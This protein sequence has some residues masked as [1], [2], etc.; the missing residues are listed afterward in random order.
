MPIAA[1]NDSSSLEDCAV[2]SKIPILPPL[3]N[4]K[5]A[6]EIKSTKNETK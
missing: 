4:R 3:T 6:N 2:R 5:I 1:A